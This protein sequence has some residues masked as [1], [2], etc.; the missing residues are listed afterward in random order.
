LQVWGKSGQARLNH[1]RVAVV[2][3]GGTGSHVVQQL[4]HLGVGELTLIDPDLVEETNLSRL[5]G[6]VATDV[7]RPKVA[8]MAER[9]AAIDSE[10]SVRA[11]QESVI[12]IEPSL[13]AFADVIMCCTDGHGSRA[14]ITE[15]VQQ[16][17]V[18]AIDMGVEVQ[19]ERNF[20]MAGGGVRVLLPGRSCLHCMGVIDPALVREEFLTDG[21]RSIERL[22]GYLSNEDEPAPAVVALNGVVASLAV[23]ELLQLLVG[24]FESDTARIVYRADHRL[25]RTVAAKSIEGCFVCGR[26]GLIGLGDTRQ[27]P[28][29][30]AS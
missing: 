21:E 18:P 16:Y 11:A 14:L 12:E 28:R 6:A 4:A 15:L 1:S 24:M 26:D 2:G 19:P 30:L 10:I 8:V 13:L 23:M 7:G 27:L 5:V 20:S 29:R 17:L 9:V 3:V 25:V 22:R